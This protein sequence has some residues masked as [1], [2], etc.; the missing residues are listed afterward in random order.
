MPRPMLSEHGFSSCQLVPP[1][2][3][4]Q[5]RATLD[6][7]ISIHCGDLIQ[8]S[9][10]VEFHIAIVLLRYINTSGN[11]DFIL[12][13]RG[14]RNKVKEACWLQGIE[15]QLI[16][17]NYG[18]DGE[19]RQLFNQ[20]KD[21]DIIFLDEGNFLFRLGNTTLLSPFTSS[22]G[23]WRFQH[24]PQEGHHFIIEGGTHPVIMH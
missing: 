14:L 4:L 9:K 3:V 2:Q 1:I 11:H 7:N 19:A 22:L 21:A 23:D 15:Q 8:E 18:E 17:R 13:V 5:L 6:A 12:S 16:A 10:L 24:C 20:A